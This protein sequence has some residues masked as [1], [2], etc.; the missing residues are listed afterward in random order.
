[1]SGR[2]GNSRSKK[3][4]PLSNQNIYEKIRNEERLR[5]FN[6]KGS[7]AYQELCDLFGPKPSQQEL[8]SLA[9]VVSEH[10]NILLDR[11][12]TRRKKVLIKWYDEHYHLVSPFLKSKILITNQQGQPIGHDPRTDSQFIKANLP[13]PK[14]IQ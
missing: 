13:F 14:P 8:L 1:M 5:G 10:L 2:F 3:S 9:Q 7:V 12:A 4:R 11:E 6:E